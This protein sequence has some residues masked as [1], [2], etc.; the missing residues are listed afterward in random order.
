MSGPGFSQD[1]RQRQSQN[2]V[3]APQLRHSLKI[4][5]VAA[6][7]LRSVIQEELQSNPTLEE[8]PMDG[9]SLDRE[10]DEGSKA[11]DSD[12]PDR[13]EEMDFSKEFD[14]L[15]KL[16]ADW[17]DYMAQAGGA[18][19]YSSEDA[20]KR[21]HFFDS[22]VSE[23]SLQEHLM[24]QAE[25]SEMSPEQAQAMQYLVGSLD[26]R[27]FLTQTPADVALQS[28]LPLDAV[29][30][31]AKMLKTFE[32]AGIGAQS[33][34][35]CLLLQLAAKGKAE[36]LASRIVKDHF[37]LL[38]RRRIPE[39]ARKLSADMESVQSAIEEIGTLDPA[40]GRRFAED[41]NRVVVPDVTVEKDGDKWNVIL[42]N[43]YIPRLRI[44]NT[45]KEMIARGTLSKNERDY[46]RER[47][48]SG[49]F[50]INSIEQ[51]QQT[52]ERITR[53]ILKVQN[54]FFEEG[55]S[56]LR[57]LTM[58]QI[59]DAVGV[60]ETTVSRAI[61]NK[62]IQTP[63]GVF[64]FKY[65]F[66]PGYQADSGASV[67]NTSVKEMINDLVMGEDRS[68]PL[69]DQDIVAKLQEKGINI[70]RRTVAKYREELGLLPSNLRREYS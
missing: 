60:H 3:L 66:T 14:I 18:Q 68:K 62:Y 33:L 24:G 52:I 45:Y 59:A 51:R 44:S 42:N 35:E 64:D 9:V 39:I 48:R 55:I 2:L 5:Q 43:D 32:P 38:S 25:L 27:G 70:A 16:D 40:P 31:A 11:D 23:T 69:S 57:P 6:L 49:K 29:Q 34:E 30:A 63:H 65:F 10:R 37:A 4:L 50:L 15:T 8:L 47:M 1:L 22:L 36:S 13:G 20:E 19:T 54:E 46:L 61:A 53:E 7:D 41:S 56:R 26:D 17:R 28:G 21:Q 58:T 67:S 12:G